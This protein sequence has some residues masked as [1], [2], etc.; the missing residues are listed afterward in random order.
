MG[1]VVPLAMMTLRSEETGQH[2]CKGEASKVIWNDAPESS[3]QVDGVI[4]AGAEA[5]AG[6]V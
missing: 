4:P 2:E 6:S 1:K 3:N 5:A